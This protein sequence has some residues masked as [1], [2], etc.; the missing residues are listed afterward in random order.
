MGIRPQSREDLV[1]GEQEF[2]IDEK[3]Q[4]KEVR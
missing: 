2:L 1:G 4:L 3:M